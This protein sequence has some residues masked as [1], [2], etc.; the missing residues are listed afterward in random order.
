LT[1]NSFVQ[2]IAEGSGAIQIL[3]YKAQ[4][5]IELNPFV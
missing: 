4:T 5:V 1:A 2:T 3:T